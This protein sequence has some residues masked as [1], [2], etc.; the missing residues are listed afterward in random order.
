MI[1]EGK[2]TPFGTVLT[3]KVIAPVH[4]HHLGPNSECTRSTW[5]YRPASLRSDLSLIVR[6]PSIDLWPS[7]SR[8]DRQSGLSGS[9]Q[10][11][12]EMLP[13]T[14]MPLPTG[15]HHPTL[16][17]YFPLIVTLESYVQHLVGPEAWHQVIATPGPASL[18]DFLSR[19]L[20]ALEKEGANELRS[21]RRQQV[22][23]VYLT[24]QEVWYQCGM[25]Q[26]G[27]R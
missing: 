4:T 9:G 22:G 7:S 13:G 25:T 16:S 2:A 18:V 6:Q 11:S 27:T 20:V 24:Q 3:R 1:T 23:E 10:A 14:D 26:V 19:T 21:G 17:S 5:G 15:V 12:M 8:G